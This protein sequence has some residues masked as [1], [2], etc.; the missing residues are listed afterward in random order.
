VSQLYIIYSVIYLF[1]WVNCTLST[2]WFVYF[3]EST[4]HYLQCDLSISVCQLYIIYI[5]IYLFQWVNCTLSTVWFIYFSESTV[6]YLV[7]F[8]YFSGSTVH[9]LQCDLS[10]SVGQLYIIYNVIYLFHWVNC[11]LSTVWFIYFSASSV[12]YIQCMYSWP[13]EI[14]KSHCR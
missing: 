4:V 6:H 1:Q 11:T 5:V 8:I 10:I 13:T 14:D 2:V 7:W 3:S 9:Y 12:H